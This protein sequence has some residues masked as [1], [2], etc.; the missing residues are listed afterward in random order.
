MTEQQRQ[1]LSA[2]VDGELA[3]ELTRPTIAAVGSDPEMRAAWERYHLIGGMLRGD[4]LHL[5]YRAVERRVMDQLENEPA[6]VAPAA[7]KD[8]TSSRSGAFVG[9]SL[10]AAAAFVAVLAVPQLLEDGEDAIPAG[11]PL[12][13]TS[14]PQQFQISSSGQRWHV[15]RPELE[16]KLDRFLINHQARSP[17]TGIKGFIPYATVVGYEAG[18]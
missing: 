1:H 6:L 5:Q 12:A 14:A 2:L 16:H 9:V 8:H 13:A 7:R 3:P 11:P 10:A 18:R 4:G 17:V 15:D